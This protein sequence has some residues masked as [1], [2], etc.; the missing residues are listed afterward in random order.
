MVNVEVESKDK[1]QWK[2]QVGDE[3]IERAK[4][5]RSRAM[6]VSEGEREARSAR[7]SF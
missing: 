7:L 3:Q 4:E 5:T 6:G 1:E 2:E